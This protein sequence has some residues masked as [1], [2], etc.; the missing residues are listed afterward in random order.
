MKKRKSKGA[1]SKFIRYKPKGSNLPFRK[2]K[3]K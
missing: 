1:S 3:R 2:I